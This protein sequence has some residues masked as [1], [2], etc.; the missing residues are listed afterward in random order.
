M[1]RFRVVASMLGPPYMP[2]LGCLISNS[3]TFHI[4]LQLRDS[5][6][7]LAIL[8][9]CECTCSVSAVHVL[10][11][12]AHSNT[13]QVSVHSLR[14]HVNSIVSGCYIPRIIIIELY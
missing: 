6:S 2:L 7:P 12:H 3:A 10:F 13:I 9:L 1:Y 11:T 5:S 8:V 4:Y 14:F